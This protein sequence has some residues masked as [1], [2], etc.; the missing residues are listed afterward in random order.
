MSLSK[1]R[2]NVCGIFMWQIVCKSICEGACEG[3]SLC[4]EI[5]KT[6]QTHLR[7]RVRTHARKSQNMRENKT[8][9]CVNKLVVLV[10]SPECET[11]MA[12]YYYYLALTVFFSSPENI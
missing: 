8:K 7:K 6:S 5:M 9:K 3:E 11:K 10:T 2:I 4:E 1:S 12:M